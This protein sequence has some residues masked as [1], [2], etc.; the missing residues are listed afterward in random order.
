M[1]GT[2]VGASAALCLVG[3]DQDVPLVTGERQRYINADS[4]ASTPPLVA[5]ADAVA[6]FLPWYGSVHRGAGYKSQVATAAYEGAREAVGR[7]FGARQDDVVIFVRNTTDAINMLAAALPDD[8]EVLAFAFEHHA[9][10]LPW[11]RRGLRISYLPVPL[12]PSEAIEALAG[13]LRTRSAG[14]RLVA[15]TGASNVTG[16]I[17]P[18]RQIAEIAHR[19][20]ARVLLDGA[21]LAAH[22]PLDLADLEL[23]YVAVSGHKMYAPFGAGA[24]IGRPDWLGAGAPYLRG[25]GAVDFVT[26]ED[27]VW[28]ALP[29]RQ[30]AGTP[31]VLGAVAMGAACS[32]LAS[33]GMQRLSREE[34]AAGRYVRDRLSRIDGITA[35]HLWEGDSPRLGIITFNMAGRWHSELAAILSAEYGIGVRHGCFCAHPLLLHLLGV[36][37]DNAHAVRR[38]IIKGDRSTVPGAVRISIGVGMGQSDV[39]AVCDALASVA[40]HGPRWKYSLDRATGGYTPD[41]ETRPM[42]PGAFELAGERLRQPL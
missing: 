31:N 39:D 10:L 23:D 21:Q 19:Y 25:G 3:A 11:R 30:E 17:L 18:Y 27:V 33:Y 2:E 6:E 1:S 28:S 38:E 35:Y 15:V 37:E 36:S 5:V 12:G 42:P 40:A 7:F 41:P 14:P 29:D 9:N 13:V 26:M 20:G 22:F 8:T 34:I 24:L 4:A 16:E 32:A